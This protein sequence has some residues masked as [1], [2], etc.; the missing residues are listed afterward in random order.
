MDSQS[1]TLEPAWSDGRVVGSS[2][3]HIDAFFGSLIGKSVRSRSRED[4]LDSD[5]VTTLGRG[6]SDALT[7]DVRLKGPS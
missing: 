4:S 1:L 6:G 5:R 3:R 7:V 2:G